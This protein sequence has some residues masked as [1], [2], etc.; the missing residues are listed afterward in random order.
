MRSSIFAIAAIALVSA[1]ATGSFSS[2]DTAKVKSVSRKE[3]ILETPDK[4]MFLRDLPP[5]TNWRKVVKRGERV[6]LVYDI[7]GKHYRSVEFKNGRSIP[8]E[9]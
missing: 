7:S 4:V 5:G 6:K 1:C 2:Y 8:L 9:Q 3:I